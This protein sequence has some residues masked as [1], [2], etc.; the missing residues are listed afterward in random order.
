MI[1]SVASS[2]LFFLLSLFLPPLSLFSY[3]LFRPFSPS[4]GPFTL[5]ADPQTRGG[6][7]H[8]QPQKRLERCGW[9]AFSGSVRDRIF[10]TAFGDRRAVPESG[11]IGARCCR[12][13]W[14]TSR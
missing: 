1:Q 10:R 12:D 13:V 7:G 11:L 14:L 9:G 6:S 3:T 8:F 4:Y 5:E 2:T